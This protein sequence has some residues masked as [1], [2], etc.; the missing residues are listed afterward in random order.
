MYTP[1]N[2]S[3]PS[4]STTMPPTQLASS[5]SHNALFSLSSHS[6]QPSTSEL[7]H[8]HASPS[9]TN[10]PMSLQKMNTIHH[11]QNYEP[12]VHYP[13]TADDYDI[14]QE[15][16][17]GAFATVYRATVIAT[18]EEVAI[19]IID[20]EQFN[21]NWS[22]EQRTQSTAQQVEGGKA[23]SGSVSRGRKHGSEVER[24][25]ETT[26]DTSH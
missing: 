14:L 21:T 11:L 23:G 4:T 18:G 7:H 12:E 10:S 13:C 19:K 26:V 20:L 17:I 1:P 2:A 8:L 16:G 25:R 6:R 5:S 24:E 9:S 22:V 15:I 3:R